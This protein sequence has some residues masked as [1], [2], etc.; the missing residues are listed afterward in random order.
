MNALT[1]RDRLV[2]VLLAAGTVALSMASASTL[3]F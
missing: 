3:T 1:L 2:F